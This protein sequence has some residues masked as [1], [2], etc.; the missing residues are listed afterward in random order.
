VLG[1]SPHCRW[2]PFGAQGLHR[3][4]ELRCQARL[5]CIVRLAPSDIR[6]C[7]RSLRHGR[8]CSRQLAKRGDV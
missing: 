3:P 2:P 4:E 5:L 8:S 6:P 7:P 1:P